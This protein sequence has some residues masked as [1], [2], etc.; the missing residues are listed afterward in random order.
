MTAFVRIVA[1]VGRFVYRFVV[2][3]DWIVAVVMLLALAITAGMVA[4]GIN[5][6]WP[7]PLLAVLMTGVSLWRR[8]AAARAEGKMPDVVAR[9][10]P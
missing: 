6:W 3:D 2:G 5:A 9:Q 10:P 7:V 4:R 8:R 1:G